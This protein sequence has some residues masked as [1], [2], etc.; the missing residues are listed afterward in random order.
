RFGV[1]GRCSNAAPPVEGGEELQLSEQPAPYEQWL[2]DGLQA[3][4]PGQIARPAATFGVRSAGEVDLGARTLPRLTGATATRQ[5]AAVWRAGGPGKQTA[6]LPRGVAY[7]AA[8]VAAPVAGRSRQ[9]TRALPH[10]AGPTAAGGPIRTCRPGGEAGAV[11]RRI[12]GPAAA[13]RSGRARRSGGNTARPDIA[14]EGAALI[15]EGAGGA[16]R[17]ARAEVPGGVA[18]TVAAGL[19]CGAATGL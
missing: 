17:Q 11:P 19:G 2:P 10:L 7:P 13:V 14:Q 3:S 18:Q 9:E 4:S 15:E 5:A 16:C 6:A 8:T 12:A 1:F